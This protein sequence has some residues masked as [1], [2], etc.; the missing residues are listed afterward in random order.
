[1][2]WSEKALIVF[3]SDLLSD[4]LFFAMLSPFTGDFVTS[5]MAIVENTPFLRLSELVELLKLKP[6]DKLVLLLE[7]SPAN[8]LQY[9]LVVIWF[10]AWLP[11]FVTTGKRDTVPLSTL[12]HSCI[13]E[14]EYLLLGVSFSGIL[15]QSLE[16]GISTSRYF[17]FVQS[18]SLLAEEES[19]SWSLSVSSSSIL[20]L[21][22][23][24]ESE[25]IDLSDSIRLM[26]LQLPMEANGASLSSVLAWSCSGTRW[27]SS[28]R[29]EL[30]S[31]GEI[32]GVG[33]MTWRER[34]LWFII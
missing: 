13:L 16:P 9:K 33:W 20:S 12:A 19:S 25:P 15:K 32:W 29:P 22:R 34:K 2:E 23:K 21:L 31:L 28:S 26:A 7:L 8:P 1:M 5:M 11:K 6:L 4:N 18:C 3:G 14:S 17:L 10:P 27:W 30:L 24:T